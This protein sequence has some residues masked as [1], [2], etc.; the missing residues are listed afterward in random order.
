MPGRQ[1]PPR[2]GWD[3]TLGNRLAAGVE[4]EED[5]FDEGALMETTEMVAN[6][7]MSAIFLSM[8]SPWFAISRIGGQRDL[9]AAPNGFAG[10]GFSNR[11]PTQKPLFFGGFRPTRTDS[12]EGFATLGE[13]ADA[14]RGEVRT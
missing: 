1:G 10:D 6:N 5:A 7:P 3:S 9:H 14:G 4:T 13:G 12:R 8:G 11:W 2:M